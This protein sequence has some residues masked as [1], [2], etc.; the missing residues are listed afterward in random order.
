MRGASRTYD[1]YNTNLDRYTEIKAS[2]TITGK[3]LAKDIDLAKKGQAAEY[4]FT[5]NC[6]TGNHRLST[7]SAQKLTDAVQQSCSPFSHRV[8][9]DIAPTSSRV[10]AVAS[11]S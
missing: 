3:Q 7:A 9:N 10:D 5:G 6:L 1:V 2:N 11:A 8:A 4:I